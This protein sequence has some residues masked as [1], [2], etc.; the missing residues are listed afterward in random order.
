MQKNRCGIIGFTLIELLI[1]IAIIGILATIAYP[2]YIDHVRKVRR[3]DAQKDLM[4]LANFMERRFSENN[5]YKVDMNGNNITIPYTRSPRTGP[6]IFYNLSLS[7]QE[8]YTYTLRA[9][10]KDAQQKDRCEMLTIDQV[11]TKKAA[12]AGCWQ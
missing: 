10:P 11:G 4:I 2:N 8:T 7:K 3:A 9:A 12:Q 1:V 6:D 5:S